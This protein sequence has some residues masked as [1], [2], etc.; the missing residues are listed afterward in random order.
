MSFSSTI[1]CIY[2][3]VFVSAALFLDRVLLQVNLAMRSYYKQ[4]VFHLLV[5]HMR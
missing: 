1:F 2:K 3:D 4:S 5:M